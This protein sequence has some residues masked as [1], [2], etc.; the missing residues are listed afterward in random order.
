MIDRAKIKK[1]FAKALKAE[2]LSSDRL[3]TGPP[4]KGKDEKR[5]EDTGPPRDDKGKLVRDG[6]WGDKG[7]GIGSGK[8]KGKERDEVDEQLERMRK[9]IGQSSGVDDSMT[10]I[11]KR[12]RHDLPPTTT[13]TSSK[14]QPSSSTP[15]ATSASVI[16]TP[17]SLRTLKRDAYALH[18]SSNPHQT[19]TPSAVHP[20]RTRV[21]ASKAKSAQETVVSRGT[22]SGSRG[23]GVVVGGGRGRQPSGIGGGGRGQPKMAARMDV[24][25]E[26]IKRNK[27]T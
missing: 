26:K 24:L 8:G 10:A 12:K 19:P 23:G 16:P 9:E 11:R 15:T 22:P 17:T 20:S 18:H 21:S 27:G 13:A 4:E 5:K 1:S 3:R 2:G 14:S 25:L 7:A 6:G